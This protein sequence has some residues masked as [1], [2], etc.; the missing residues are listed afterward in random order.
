MVRAVPLGPGRQVGSGVLGEQGKAVTQFLLVSVCDQ[1]VVH[2][3]RRYHHCGLL[4][5][6]VVPGSHLINN[7]NDTFLLLN[8]SSKYSLGL[9]IFSKFIFLSHLFYNEIIKTCLM[10]LNLLIFMII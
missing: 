9:S 2:E 4:L 6:A 5:G 1:G 7:R 8:I 3:T 10:T